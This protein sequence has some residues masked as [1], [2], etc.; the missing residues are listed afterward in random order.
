MSKDN[1]SWPLHRKV[2]VLNIIP[3]HSPTLISIEDKP[4]NKKAAKG[5]ACLLEW[6]ILHDTVAF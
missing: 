4:A 5:H 3:Y 2:Q 1:Q 6:H